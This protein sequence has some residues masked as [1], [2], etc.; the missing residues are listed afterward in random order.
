MEIF[1]EIGIE[2]IVAN[3][4]PDML[5]S[6][7]ITW[8]VTLAGRELGRCSPLADDYPRMAVVSP[9]RTTQFPQNRLEP[10]F[11]SRLEET[12]GIVFY[13]RHQAEAITQADGVVRVE[14]TDLD[15]GKK[16]R[17]KARYL[18]ACDGSAS[19]TRDALGIDSVGDDLQNM[20]GIHFSADLGRFIENRRSMLYWIL[21][22]RVLGVLIAHW[23]PSEWVL[24]TPSFPPSLTLE[25]FTGARCEELIHQAIGT[26]SIADLKIE[27]A[28]AWMLGARLAEK[29]RQGRVFLA[30]DA[31]HIFPPTGGLG[32]NTGVQD[33]HNLAWKLGAVLRGDAQEGLLDSYESERR[34]V[35]RRNLEHS[36]S[37]Y[38]R[39]NELI[40]FLGLDMKG[41]KTLAGVQ[42]S[43]PFRIFPA[44]WKRSLVSRG[45]K[46]ALGR[47]APLDEFGPKAE[48]ARAHFRGLVPGQ[49]PH[50]RFMG[51]DLGFAYQKGAII[52]DAVPTPEPEYGVQ[53]YLPTTRPGSRLPHVHVLRKGV[54]L[55][56]HDLIDPHGYLLFTHPEG[57]ADWIEAARVL[58]G[59]I[60]M[61]VTCLSIGR[62]NEA[63]LMDE[64]GAWE[65]LSEVDPTGAVL[66]RPD[67]H[68]AWRSVRLPT[69]PVDELRGVLVMLGCRGRKEA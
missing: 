67:G 28:G 45:V 15:S 3:A 21:N 49:S 6:G 54:S 1:R 59:E 2:E 17:V 5:E 51:L 39:M 47:L 24:F 55:S 46:I 66:V 43:W 26:S 22:R 8:A 12:S 44:A 42:A 52:P 13:K 35:A 30:G 62:T 34:P 14:F 31:A 68:V 4:R 61:P 7:I 23:P 18:I 20:I 60:S 36:V 40:G 37:N 10:L 65:R 69:S 25:Q 9:T 53:D 64:R 32:L 16:K 58:Q 33:A 56:N 27:G 41:F 50:Y 19:G 11:W 57:Q 48:K 38:E 29:Y 63:D